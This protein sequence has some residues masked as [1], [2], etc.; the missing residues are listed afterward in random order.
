MEIIFYIFILAV[1]FYVLVWSGKILVL[2]LSFMA[3][4][5][6]VSEYA[7][8]FILMASATSLPE[9]FVGISSSLAGNPEISFGNIVGANIIN[10]TLAVALIAILAKSIKI[11]SEEP[12]RDSFLAFAIAASPIIFALDGV[13]S[14]FDGAILVLLFFGHLV[15]LIKYGKRDDDIYNS[16][17]RELKTLKIFIKNFGKF[18]AGIVILFGSGALIVWAAGNI[19][20]IFKLPLFVIGLVLVSIGTTLPEITFGI[21]SVFSGKESMAMGNILGSAVTNSALIL[22]VVAILSPIQINN[23][24]VVFSSLIMMVTA[25][26]LFALLV[27]YKKVITYKDGL[28]LLVFYIVF[29]G[30]EFLIK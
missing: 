3:K 18:L 16:I 11:T 6:G 12:R 23:F 2:S 10:V 25:L 14:R 24:K 29:L 22:G 19:A 1:S 27:R 13:I 4:F 28:I 9:F 17:P 15:Y 30:V 20:D 7:A 8:S 21:R 26:F 5:L